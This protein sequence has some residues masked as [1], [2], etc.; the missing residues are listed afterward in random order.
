M[1][2]NS[3]F[4]A[5]TSTLDDGGPSTP[6]PGRLNASNN[7]VH[8]LQES[9]WAPQPVWKGARKLSPTGYNP[10]TVQSGLHVKFNLNNN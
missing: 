6:R 8:T 10:W 4:K 1:G 3:G 5:L 2:F 7:S 9:G